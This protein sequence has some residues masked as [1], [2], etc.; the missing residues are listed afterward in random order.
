MLTPPTD[1]FMCIIFL[2]VMKILSGAPVE[3]YISNSY[4][5]VV[6]KISAPNFMLLVIFLNS[7]LDALFSRSIFPGIYF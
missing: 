4:C 2:L 1:C 7:Q 5:L 3:M 6:Y